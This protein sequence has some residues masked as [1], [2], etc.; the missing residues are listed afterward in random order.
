MP[1]ERVIHVTDL[2]RGP[3][4]SLAAFSRHMQL[5]DMFSM[6]CQI[7]RSITCYEEGLKIQSQTLGDTDT[8]VGETCRFC[9]LLIS[10]LNNATW[11]VSETP[12]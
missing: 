1:L 4:H 5:G 3:D 9:H 12:F 6:L 2:T 7:D 8:R 11:L 10:Q